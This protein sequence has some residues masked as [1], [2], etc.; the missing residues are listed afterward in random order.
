KRPDLSVVG[1]EARLIAIAFLKEL[2][3]HALD[4]LGELDEP[5]GIEG[6]TEHLEPRAVGE[7]VEGDGAIGVFDAAFHPGGDAFFEPGGERVLEDDLGVLMPPLVGDDGE[8]IAV[9]AFVD[10]KEDGGAAHA[11]P[12]AAEIEVERSAIL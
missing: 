6:V 9:A 8:R 5:A 1:E 7:A 12:A 4:K 11:V 3:G 2:L 10:I